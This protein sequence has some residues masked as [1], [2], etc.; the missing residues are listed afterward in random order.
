M[1][2]SD[3]IRLLRKRRKR[4]QDDVAN[5]LGIKR[6]TLCS[7]ENGSTEPSMDTLMRF[8][9]YFKVSLDTLI[10]V[11][12]SKVSESLLSEIEKGHDIDISGNKLRILATIVN[13]ENEENI[14]LVPLKAKAG[15][16]AGFADPSYIKVLQAFSLPFLDRNRKYRSFEISGDSMPPVPHGSWVVAEYLENWNHIK[17]G[18]P[19]IILTKD[20]GIVF[21][22]VYNKIGERKSL[23]LVS[24]NPEYQPYEIDISEVLEVW[25]FSTYMSKEL[26]EPNLSKDH[27]S[28]TLKELRMEIA[29]IKTELKRRNG[30]QMRIF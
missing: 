20:E 6:T 16:T 24:T 21:K 25:K 7:Y 14:E 22:S 5:T 13:Q 8:S 11:E 4:S 18:Y 12:L 30:E 2:F 15:Y 3:N 27:L 29:E 23:M 19:Y 26:P 1:H 10:K 17:D 28:N 9:E